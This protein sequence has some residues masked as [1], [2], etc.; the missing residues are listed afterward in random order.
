MTP[1]STRPEGLTG[2]RRPSARRTGTTPRRSTSRGG[3]ETETRTWAHT[4]GATEWKNA[5]YVIVWL[6]TT[7]DGEETVMSSD[8]RNTQS[9][10]SEVEDLELQQGDAEEVRGGTDPVPTE[11]LSFNYTK[12]KYEY[13]P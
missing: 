1:I 12:P 4:S 9:E 11:S 2:T 3:R 6:L 5:C 13:K 10:P 7:L 8:E